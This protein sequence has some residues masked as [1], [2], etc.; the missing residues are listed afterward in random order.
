[1]CSRERI[2]K[3]YT[4]KKLIKYIIQKWK[5]NVW[6]IAFNILYK[7]LK[8]NNKWYYTY[9]LISNTNFFILF[10]YIFFFVIVVSYN[11]E[12]PTIVFNS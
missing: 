1:M 8:N 12:T 2:K 4:M 5:E 6:L 11:K 7:V 3:M 9:I 10:I